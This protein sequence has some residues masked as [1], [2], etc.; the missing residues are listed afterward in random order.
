V[1][2]I[3]PPAPRSSTL[4]TANPGAAHFIILDLITLK[5]YIDKEDPRFI[6]ADH[7]DKFSEDALPRMAEE[8]CPCPKVTN[9]RES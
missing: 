5:L 8:F 7:N 2:V 4:P 9:N 1:N 6:S 3:L